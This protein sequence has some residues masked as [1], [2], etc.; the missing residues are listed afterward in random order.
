MDN[1]I[2]Y[3]YKYHQEIMNE[4]NGFLLSEQKL[5]KITGVQIG[6]GLISLL[7]NIKEIELIYYATSN[8]KINTA[9]NNNK[10]LILIG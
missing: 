7:K 6:D 3:K 10:K 4:V 9:L 5:L 2:N 8:K 1:K